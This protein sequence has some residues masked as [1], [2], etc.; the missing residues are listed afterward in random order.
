MNAENSPNKSF[1]AASNNCFLSPYN[2]RPVVG[3][4]VILFKFRIL[5]LQKLKLNNF[6]LKIRYH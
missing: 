1:S 5:M 3:Y 4:I 6:T 2:N